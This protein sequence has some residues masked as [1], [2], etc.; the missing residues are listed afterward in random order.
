MEVLIN[1]NRK[2]FP[3]KKYIVSAINEINN[4][5]YLKY[6]LVKMYKIGQLKEFNVLNDYEWS[7]KDQ[8][9]MKYNVFKAAFTKEFVIVH[10][11]P[12]RPILG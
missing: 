11:A 4:P 6:L 10:L 7:L 3:M 2:H 1:M 5:S 12:E 8:N 9:E